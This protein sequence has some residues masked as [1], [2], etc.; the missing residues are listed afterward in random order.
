MIIPAEVWVEGSG[1]LPI[2]NIAQSAFYGFKQIREIYFSNPHA[3]GD[4][5]G[6]ITEI[7]A[8]AFAGLSNLRNVVFMHSSLSSVIFGTASFAY[9][10]SL[11]EVYFENA[12]AGCYI[13]DMYAT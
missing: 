11:N 6:G 7:G 5:D 10:T 12:P 1:M 9:A 8:Y 3:Y 4:D 13:P 2:T